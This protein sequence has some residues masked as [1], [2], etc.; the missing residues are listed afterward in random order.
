VICNKHSLNLISSLLRYK[1]YHIFNDFS[2]LYCVILSWYEKWNYFVFSLFYGYVESEKNVGQYFC[3]ESHTF[4]KF[5]EGW[6]ES[7]VVS[8]LAMKIY[9]KGR[10]GCICIAPHILNLGTRWRWVVSFMPWPLYPQGNYLGLNRRLVG[11]QRWSWTLWRKENCLFLTRNQ[12]T[13]SLFL[14]L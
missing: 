7:K 4:L 8:V 13:I 1:L 6:S 3:P 11:P 12:T 5:I 2:Y 14:R 9:W 10:R